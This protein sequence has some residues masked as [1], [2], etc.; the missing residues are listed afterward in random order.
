MVAALFVASCG[1]RVGP[2]GRPNCD[3][4][5][6]PHGGAP[7]GTAPNARPHRCADRYADG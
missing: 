3:T 1:G 2:S 6:S 5:S 4:G 7:G